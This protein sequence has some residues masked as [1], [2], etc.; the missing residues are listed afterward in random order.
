MVMNGAQLHLA[1]NHF[2]VVTVFLSLLLLLWSWK[3]KSAELQKAG[4]VFV[5]LC[6]VFAGASFLTGDPAEHVLDKLPGFSDKL[7]DAHEEAADFALGISIVSGV[8][9]LVSLFFSKS[10]PKLAARA[11]IVVILLTALSCTVFLRTAH[12]GG[13]IKHDEI[14]TAN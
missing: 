7:L 6:A 11:Y 10:K 1:I 14:R 8:L 2:P 9:A 13:L 5:V 12:L 3:C 4:L